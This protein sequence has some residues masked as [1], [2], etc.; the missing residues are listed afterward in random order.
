MKQIE[1]V[2]NIIN[3]AIKEGRAGITSEKGK[4]YDGIEM[5]VNS[6]GHILFVLKED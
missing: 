6:K 1:N 5:R 3:T 2:I 4:H